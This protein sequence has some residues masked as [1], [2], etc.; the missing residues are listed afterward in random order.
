M[1]KI[2]YRFPDCSF[3]ASAKFSDTSLGAKGQYCDSPLRSLMIMT[4][5][6]LINFTILRKSLIVQAVLI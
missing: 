2:I 5:I 3:D 1:F 6:L 4:T